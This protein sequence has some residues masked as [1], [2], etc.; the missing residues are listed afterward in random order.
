V[1]ELFYQ[2]FDKGMLE[3]GE[4]RKIDFKNTLIIL[5]S[6]IGTELIMD[7]CYHDPANAPDMHT[8]KTLLTPALQ[9]RFKPAFLGRLQVVPYYPI[10]DDV[11]R[12]IIR[13]KMDRIADRVR[14]N[15]EIVLTYGDELVDLVAAR[16]TEVDS[17]ARNVDHILT[18][19]LLPELSRRILEK[20]AAEE[21]IRTIHVTSGEKGFEF[22]FNQPAPAS[23]AAAQHMQPMEVN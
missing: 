17:G 10:H 4:G 14:T 21:Q 1:T 23:G 16:C 19:T 11:M 15:G 9:R 3:D 12:Q 5:T 18:D 20:M 22:L 7:R 8:L 2:V 6:N 13:L